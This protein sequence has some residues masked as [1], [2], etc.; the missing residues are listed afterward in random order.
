M[1]I[2]IPN[3]EEAKLLAFFVILIMTL[4]ISAFFS[5]VYSPECAIFGIASVTAQPTGRSVEQSLTY[6][7][8]AIR[9]LAVAEERQAAAIEAFVALQLPVSNTGG[10]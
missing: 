5:G 7:G 2:N 6:I 1:K 9:R 8:D 4:I 3:K 10:L